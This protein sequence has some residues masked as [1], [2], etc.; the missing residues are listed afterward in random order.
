MEEHNEIVEISNKETIKAL[1]EV[2]EV[3]ENPQDYKSYSLEEFKDYLNNV[4]EC[5]M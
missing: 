1:N 5:C 2:K 3:L 4:E